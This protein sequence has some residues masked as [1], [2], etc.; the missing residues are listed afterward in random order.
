[1][2]TVILDTNFLLLPVQFK[3]DIFSEISDLLEEKVEFI[4]FDS[5]LK[6]LS[7]ISKSKGKD[8]TAARVALKLLEEGNIRIIKGQSK[9][10]DNDIISYC[11]QNKNTLVA[12]ND[13]TLRKKLKRIGVRVIFLRGRKKLDYGS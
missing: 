12:T 7:E 8:G 9:N 5:T 13:A 3:I 10:V 6:E 11:K 4:V 1:M 2:R